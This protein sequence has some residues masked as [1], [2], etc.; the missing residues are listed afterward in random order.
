MPVDRR[1]TFQ[2]DSKRC[3]YFLTINP[4]TLAR[5]DAFPTTLS[6]VS[7]ELLPESG[8]EMAIGEKDREK[9][10]HRALAGPRR[11]GGVLQL[12]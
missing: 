10:R 3:T 7:I 5:P 4:E 9:P 6:G 12:G 1:V 2:F 8:S 11:A